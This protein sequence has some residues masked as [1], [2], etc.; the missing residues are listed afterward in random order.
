MAVKAVNSAHQNP[1]R[2]DFCPPHGVAE[3]NV[4]C[5]V[6]MRVGACATPSRPLAHRHHHEAHAS[7]LEEKTPCLGITRTHKARAERKHAL[8]ECDKGAFTS[9]PHNQFHRSFGGHC[10]HTRRL[11]TQ[12]RTDALVCGSRL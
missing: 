12:G 8:C 1:L 11:L 4:L 7:Y 10:N 3:D 5:C 9:P 2:D 6:Y